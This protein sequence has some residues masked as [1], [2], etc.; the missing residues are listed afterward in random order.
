MRKKVFMSNYF[1]ISP[2]NDGWMNLAADEWFLDHL[3]PQDMILYF[4][5]NENAVIIGKNQNPWKECDLA[6]MDHDGVQLVRRITGGGAVYHDM[7][8]LNFSFIAGE[9]IYDVEKQLNVILKAVRSFGIPC[10]FSGRNDLL[11]DG[12]KFSG[13]AFIK[14]GQMCQHHGTLLLN[15]N[16]SKLQNYLRPD[17][18]KLQAKGVS[19]V[20]SRVCNLQEFTPAVTA[21]A[22][23]TAIRKSF[24]ETYG[25]V[26]DFQPTPEELTAMMLYRE[27]QASWDWRLGKT[28]GFDLELDTRFPWGGVQIL[29][30]AKN[31]IVT[32]VSVYSDAM[33]PAL[34]EE[35]KIRLTGCRFS[36]KDLAEA[37]MASEKKTMQDIAKFILSENL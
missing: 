25:E 36:S 31:S 24:A 22:M 29:L 12:R 13:N 4:Y 16:L 37:L 11:A 18:R 2:S 6:A 21:D 23:L 17:P 20:R 35:V 28:P 7:G 8:N 10:E 19:S 3:Q 9:G 15:A 34:P 1:Y 32:E 26:I 33:D 14:R 27:K 30:T 5:T